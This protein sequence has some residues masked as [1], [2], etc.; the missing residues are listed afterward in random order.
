LCNKRYSH[1]VLSPKENLPITVISDDERENG[2]QI[3]NISCKDINGIQ[4]S[5]KEITLTPM[6][7]EP[8][9]DN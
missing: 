7:Y 5:Q 6:F 4:Y 8:T 1:D 3:K 9:Q 2:V